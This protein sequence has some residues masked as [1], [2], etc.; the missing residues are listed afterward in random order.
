MAAGSRGFSVNFDEAE[1]FGFLN[2][3]NGPVA[4]HL[5]HLA[6]VGTQEAKRLA[7]TSPHGSGGRPSGWLRSHIGWE[8]HDDSRGLYVDIG[9]DARTPQGHDYGLDVE[10]GT[11]PHIIRSRGPWPLRNKRAGKVFGREVHHP[12]TRPQPFLRAALEFLRTVQ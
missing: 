4:R 12:G 9:C 8:L 1:L 6:E 5:Q 7:P 3:P 11:K 2:G 10:L